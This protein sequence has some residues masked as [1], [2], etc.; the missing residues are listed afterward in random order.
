MPFQPFTGNI[1]D[2]PALNQYDAATDT[3]TGFYDVLASGSLMWLWNAWFNNYIAIAQG[4]TLEEVSYQ[5]PI[6][7]NSTFG[8][9]A[10]ESSGWGPV[11]GTGQ[12]EDDG[13]IVIADLVIWLIEQ[14]GGSVSFEDSSYSTWTVTGGSIQLPDACVDFDQYGGAHYGSFQSPKD[15]N[16]SLAWLGYMNVMGHPMTCDPNI[17]NPPPPPP[18]EPQGWTGNLCD[19]P[20]IIDEFGNITQESVLAG[21]AAWNYNTGVD[22]NLATYNFPDLNGD[23]VISQGDLNALLAEF[24]I[25]WPMNCT[26][27]PPIGPGDPTGP[28]DPT[29]PTTGLGGG[30]LPGGSTK[31]KK[32]RVAKENTPPQ[33]ER[34]EG[35]RENLRTAGG[36]YILPN[37]QIYVGAYHIH[38]TMGAMV[39]ARHTSA[40]HDK[41]LPYTPA[42]AVIPP[43]SKKTEDSPQSRS[44]RRGMGGSGMSSGSG[45]N[46]Y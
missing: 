38:P 43:K 35:V 12:F 4:A 30:R 46:T 17:I 8:D 42:Q 13:R 39:G 7:A 40:P 23:E 5:F 33:K 26:V 32:G 37:G 6:W 18:D 21:F 20:G 16:P 2:Y 44:K 34:Y 3:Y 28:S 25:T 10:G 24:G 11:G 9:I 22:Q 29:G 36:E 14:S 27:G 15:Y 19:Y 41:L 1:C 45:S 31:S